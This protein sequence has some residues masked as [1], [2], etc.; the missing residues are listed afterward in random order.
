MSQQLSFD[1]TEIAF[2]YKSEKDLKDSS[3][4]FKM[5]GYPFLVKIGIPL[6]VWS[7]KAKLPVK[8]LIRNTI[9]KQFA[10]GESL[11]QTAT[12]ANTLGKYKVDIILDYA[13]EGG[14]AS[15]AEYDHAAGEF[16]KVIDYAATQ[17]NIPFM[18]VKV[19]GLTRFSLL[20]KLDVLMHKREGTLIKKYLGALEDL[21][22]EDRE[23]W[24]RVRLRMMRVCEKAA[25]KNVGMLV[26]AEETWIQDP[27]DALIMLMMDSFNKEKLIIYNTVQH[28]RQDR[29]Q[30]L[31]DS[32]DAAKERGFLLGVK[33]VRGAYMEK[34]R[35]R[36]ESLGY[37]SPIQPDKESSDRD[38]NAGVSLCLDNIDR[39]GVIV[40]SH[41]EDSNMLAVKKLH[42]LNQPLN[43]PHVNFSQLFGMSDN[44]TFNLAN[45]GCNVSKY[46]PFGPIEDVIPYLMRRAQENTSIKG[47]TGRELGLILKEIKRRHSER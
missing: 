15:D 43:H 44:I 23:E 22:K 37:P 46:L 2:Q 32:I 47:Q 6:T 18:S 8:G 35:E 40:A 19:T 36:A 10:G 34:E 3:L 25:E 38:F 13:V 31:K 24:H 42:E 4:L 14:D 5:M 29:L 16:I 17:S 9:F 21:S 28:Y 30:F 20:E 33:L 27:V 39:V 1:N 11:Q 26:D 41:N 45:A 7:V 12:V